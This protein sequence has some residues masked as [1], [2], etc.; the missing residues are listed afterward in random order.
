MILMEHIYVKTKTL[1][2]SKTHREQLFAPSA[3]HFDPSFTHLQ[4]GSLGIVP[5]FSP[6]PTK[7]FPQL[8]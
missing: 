8:R 3:A 6:E 4:H 1:V 5:I 2:S 7:Y